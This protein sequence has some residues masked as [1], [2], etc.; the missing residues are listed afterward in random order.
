MANVVKEK[1]SKKRSGSFFNVILTSGLMIAFVAWIFQMQ[2][3]SYRSAYLRYFGLDYNDFPVSTVD[4]QWLALHGWMRVSVRWL[5]G[6]WAAVLDVLLD[7]GITVF[8]ILLLVL[9]AFLLC[10]GYREV[11]KEVFFRRLSSRI[12]SFPAVVIWLGRR[13]KEVLIVAVG[14]I[15][16]CSAAP[17]LLSI[18]LLASV[19]VVLL[20]IVPFES[21]GRDAARE[22]CA[23]GVQS[24]NRLHLSRESVV[25]GEVRGLEC[26]NELC[27]VIHNGELWVISR[28]SVEATEIVHEKSGG[29]RAADSSPA[30][31]CRSW[32]VKGAPESDVAGK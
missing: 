16:A 23:K 13:C 32:Q 31:F 10:W 14:V 26:S 8:V 29:N 4:L 2:G 1:S 11:L 12:D 15:F 24:L 30:N 28:D 6:V 27:A 20:L 19:L 5:E 17:A 9:W 25:S 7:T 22:V 21:V 18:V 3:R